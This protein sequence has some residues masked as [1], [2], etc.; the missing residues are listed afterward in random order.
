MRTHILD[1]KLAIFEQLAQG[2]WSDGTPFT[3]RSLEKLE[4]PG[5]PRGGSYSPLNIL[6]TYTNSVDLNSFHLSRHFY[7]RPWQRGNR[8]T[9]TFGTK[10]TK[11]RRKDTRTRRWKT[12]ARWNEGDEGKEAACNKGSLKIKAD[13]SIRSDRQVSEIKR[14]LTCISQSAELLS[15]SFKAFHI[16]S[17][18]HLIV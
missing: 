11:R 6:L 10:R 15:G 14:W 7:S 18:S 4:R 17:V 3:T 16:S 2:S 1:R 13:G 12:M 8:G 5:H 9:E